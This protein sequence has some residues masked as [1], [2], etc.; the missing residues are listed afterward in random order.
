[1]LTPDRVAEYRRIVRSVSAWAAGREDVAGVAVVGSW[2]RDQAR[3]DSDVDFVV[4]TDQQAR[5][6]ADDSWV[7][8]ALGERAEFLRTAS[9]GVLA[10]W[11]VALPSGLEVEFG[12]VPRSWASA[13]PVD[14][15]T[16]QVVAE[17]CSPLIDREGALA[18]LIAAVAAT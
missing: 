16:R 18:R 1:M 13:D 6:L 4:L 5:Y 10:E 3:I 12:F 2:A 8:A 15:G 17:G 11:R 14:S 9:W 7:A